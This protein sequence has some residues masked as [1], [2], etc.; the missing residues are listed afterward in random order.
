[1]RT[2]E[3]SRRIRKQVLPFYLIISYRSNR[4]ERQMGY[5][6]VEPRVAS[7]FPHWFCGEQRIRTERF[8]YAALKKCSVTQSENA[9]KNGPAK[10]AKKRECVLFSST[11]SSSLLPN[12]TCRMFVRSGLFR[13]L[14]RDSRANLFSV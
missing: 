9:S 11:N 14:S 12:C 5:E 1:M 3:L 13:V 8:G 6:S 10:H 2:R 7:D 4:Q